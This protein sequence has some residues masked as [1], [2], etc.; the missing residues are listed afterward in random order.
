MDQTLAFHTG[1]YASGVRTPQKRCSCFGRKWIHLSSISS[2][3]S[4]KASRTL[5][6][7][8]TGSSSL[9]REPALSL[10]DDRVTISVGLDS[11]SLKQVVVCNGVCQ[12]T[13]G[14]VAPEAPA[15]PGTP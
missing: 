2:W 8:G 7:L 15:S 4:R 6:T 11:A 3:S 10:N 5:Q 1:T 13:L 12:L 14:P 9:S